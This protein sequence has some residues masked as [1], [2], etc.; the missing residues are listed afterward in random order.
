MLP[1]TIRCIK[2]DYVKLAVTRLCHFFNAIAHK[3][4]DPAE[5]SALSIEIAETLC[6]L[7]M[8][9]PLSLFDMLVHLLG[10]IVD[11]IKILG[12]VFLHQM[13]PFERYMAVLKRYVRNR[14]NPKGCMIQGYHTEEVVGSCTDYIDGT[15]QRSVPPSVH[16]GRWG[17]GG[18]GGRKTGNDEGHNLLAEVHAIILQELQMVASYATKHIDELRMLHED[19]QDEWIMKLHKLQFGPWLKK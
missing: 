7:E 19:K 14:A 9:F 6:P 4:I 5:L 3:V 18:R 11:E 10:H 2:P 17:G 8:V 13:Y 1:I 15:E 16:E 12:L